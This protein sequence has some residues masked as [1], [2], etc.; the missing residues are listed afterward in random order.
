[1]LV[2]A[3]VPLETDGA[4]ARLSRGADAVAVGVDAQ[5]VA[6]EGRARRVRSFGNLRAHGNYASARE[7]NT[8]SVEVG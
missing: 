5:V 2:R 6:L 3:A 4:H 7:W 8:E 1:M